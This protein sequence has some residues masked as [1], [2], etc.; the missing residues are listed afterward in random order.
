MILIFDADKSTSVLQG[1]ID[2][3]AHQI[4][5]LQTSFEGFERDL[6]DGQEMRVPVHGMDYHIKH[7]LN[8]LFTKKLVKYKDPVFGY[9]DEQTVVAMRPEAK[10]IGLHTI[11]LDS[12]SGM[13]E[14]IRLALIDDSKFSS[15]SKDLWGKYAV[16]LS[17]VTAMVRDLPVNV[18]VTCHI[19]Y[20]EDDYGLPLHFP[21]VKGSQKTDMLRWFDV[22]VYTSVTN[23]GL[24]KWQVKQAEARPFIRSRKDIPEWAGKESVDPDFGPIYRCYAEKPVKILLIGDSGTWKT[25]SLLTIPIKLRGADGAN[26]RQPDTGESTD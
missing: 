11:V 4:R 20:G 15:M 18:V 6:V 12:I 9:E 16:R 26:K 14:A 17:R 25:S 19:D 5:Q 7:Y 8:L 2:T 1:K 24:V 23:E 3:T 22:I 13:G 21:A 10:Q